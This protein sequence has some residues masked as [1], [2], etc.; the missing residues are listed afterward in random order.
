M[1]DE[2]RMPEGA[3]GAAP[4]QPAQAP[5]VPP[6]AS[7]PQGVAPAAPAATEPMPQAPSAAPAADQAQTTAIPPFAPTND[8]PAYQQAA[9]TYQQQPASGGNGLAI[10][11]LVCGILA[12]LTVLFPI[13]AIVLGIVAI[14]L[15]VQA[16]KRGK[17]GKATAGKVT[18]GIGIALGVIV[19]IAS[20]I[21]LTS[22]LPGMTEELASTSAPSAM[23]APATSSND[24]AKS[25][26]SSADAD[27]ARDALKAYLDENLDTSA[28]QN[29]FFE[30]AFASAIEAST[31]VSIDKLGLTGADFV[32]WMLASDSYS[33]D[34][35]SVSSDGMTAT[36]QVTMQVRDYNEFNNVY[37]QKIGEA[38]SSFAASADEDE[39]YRQVGSAISD[40]MSATPMTSTTISA[41]LTKS[42]STWTVDQATQSAIDNA[43]FG[44]GN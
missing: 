38:A 33:I 12:I 1:T 18:G 41:S 15:G 39:M 32:N 23:E 40:A 31:N 21:F 26:S 24:A 9:G 2:N 34:N 3:P 42:G 7:E 4:E 28:T 10:G 37:A 8:A 29:A 17:D 36:A 6:A 11:S 13:V 43:I 44:S 35:V 5:S 16:S 27:G 25:G 14:V 19:W 20:A 22:V 30:Q